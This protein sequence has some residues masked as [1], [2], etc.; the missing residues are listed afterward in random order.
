MGDTNPIDALNE[1]LVRSTILYR[2]GAEVVERDAGGV[3][4]V[5]VFGYPQTPSRGRLVD[6]H[7]LNV[8]FTEAAC[9]RAAFR[10]AISAALG[11]GEFLDMDVATLQGGPSYRTLGVW[12]GSQ[13]QALR[14]M[15]LGAHYGLWGVITPATLH[16]EGEVA[17]ELAGSG[18]VMAGPYDPDDPMGDGTGEPRGIQSLGPTQEIVDER[19]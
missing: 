6:V 10:A 19:H 12:L 9:D 5:E 1:I 13:E 14:Y 8:G 11:H 7:F 4:V 16:I 3:H 2:K 17:D 18:F 15:A